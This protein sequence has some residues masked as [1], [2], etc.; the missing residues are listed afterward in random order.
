MSEWR[1]MAKDAGMYPLDEAA[2]HIEQEERR[3][4]EEWLAETQ[5]LYNEAQSHHT[6]APK[7]TEA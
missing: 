5:R 6:D 4:H 7:E 3:Q 2:A 1:D